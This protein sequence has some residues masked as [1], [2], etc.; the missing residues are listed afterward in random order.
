MGFGFGYDFR[1]GRNF[2][3]P[4]FFNLVFSGRNDIK[5]NDAS[6]GVN[7]SFNLIQV[8]LGFTWH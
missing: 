2:S 7:A 8:G 3:L 6:T 4:P 1:L 5:F